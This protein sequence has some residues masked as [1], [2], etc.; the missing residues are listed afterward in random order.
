MWLVTF[1]NSH[2][3][4]HVLNVR[5]IADIEPAIERA[6]TRPAPL[7]DAMRAYL[8]ER[9]AHVDGRNSARVLDAVDDFAARWQ[10]R[11]P[12]KPLNLVRKLKLRKRMHYWHWR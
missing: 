12:R 11:L 3:G 9:E 5:D 2:P 8:N 10:G 4:P 7:M 1:R 6:L